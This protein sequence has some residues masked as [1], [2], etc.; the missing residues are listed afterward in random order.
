[1][2]KKNVQPLGVT[3]LAHLITR[4]CQPLPQRKR[5][6]QATVFQMHG[7]TLHGVINESP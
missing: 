6:S 1:M 3:P 5:I 7:H 4:K 2:R